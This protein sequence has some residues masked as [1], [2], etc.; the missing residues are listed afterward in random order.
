MLSNSGHDERGQYSGG[1]AGDQGGEWSRI[2]W[3]NRPWNVV[4]RYPDRSVC[5]LIAQLAGEAADN[6]HIGYD[7]LQRTTFWQQLQ[8]S[9]YYPSRITV[10]C[11]ADC[12]AGVAAIVKAAG[13]ILGNSK[14]QSISPDAYT[15]N[16]KSALNSVYNSETYAKL[17]IPESGLYFQS[18]GYV[19]ALLHKEITTGT[20]S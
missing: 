8:K 5:S 16:L 15:G 2:K 18:E 17:S 7:Q 20:L 3:Y 13:Y 19:Y 4:L 6:D 14:L 11:E 12:S 10:D 9:G 1:K